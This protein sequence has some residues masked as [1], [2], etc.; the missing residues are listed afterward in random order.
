MNQFDHIQTR[1][2]MEKPVS[3]GGFSMGEGG[4]KPRGWDNSC[5]KSRRED[6][7]HLMR[8]LS[9]VQSVEHFKCEY[10]GEEEWD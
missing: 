1:E 8:V 6:G 4:L 5:P 2:D 3:K 7:R 10:C 9:C